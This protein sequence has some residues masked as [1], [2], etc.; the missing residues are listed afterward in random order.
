MK[1]QRVA[2]SI[3]S[4]TAVAWGIPLAQA[5]DSQAQ[6]T[7]HPKFPQLD[8]N[9]DGFVSKLEVKS[10]E[11]YEKFFT[12]ADENRDGRL[13]PSE[14]M[15]FQSLRDGAYLAQVASDSA[16]TAKV[17]AALLREPSLDSLD[18]S[19]ESYK[20]RVLLSGFVKDDA[21]RR[22]AIQVAGTVSGVTSVKDG[23]AVR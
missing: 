3:L 18:V 1:L 2:R 19:V 4:I 9:R 22:K 7:V 21:Q 5:D 17:K 12:E 14:F 11:G 6:D 16:T 10:I 20:S 15:T 23:L 13:D 8:A